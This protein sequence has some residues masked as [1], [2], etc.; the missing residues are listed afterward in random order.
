MPMEAFT[1]EHALKL[2][3]LRAAGLVGDGR[4]G[5]FAVSE[6]GTDRVERQSLW[7]FDLDSFE[8]RRLGEQLLLTGE[9]IAT[10]GHGMGDLSAPSP[11][12]DGRIMAVIAAVDGKRQIWLVPVDGSDARQLTSLP[13]GVG[14]APVWSPDG[15]TV[16]F[17]A[18]PPNPRDPALPYRIDRLSYIYERVGYIDDVIQDLYLVDV[19]SG[20]VKQ[21]TRDRSMNTDPQWSPDGRVISYLVSF[22][23][24]D[25]MWDWNAELRLLDLETGSSRTLVSDWGGVL[26]AKWCPDGKRITFIGYP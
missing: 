6:I 19:E 25:E 7:V 3:T 15:R 24:P 5:F 14:S 16:V 11:S 12:P 20:A 4:Q 2:K 22:S 10:G 21:L 8:A 9:A 17:T 1:T 18:G 23:K 26:K 13:Q